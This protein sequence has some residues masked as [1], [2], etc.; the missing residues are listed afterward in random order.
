MKNSTLRIIAVTW[1]CLILAVNLATADTESNEK[2]EESGPPSADKMQ[3]MADQLAGKATARV[4]YGGAQ[5]FDSEDGVFHPDMAIVVNGDRIESIGP[6]SQLDESQTVEAEVVNA[7]GWFAIPGLVDSHV[8]VGTLPAR[9]PAEAM[10]KR[11]LYSGIT[12]VRDMAGDARALADLSR[13]ALVNEM[14]SPDIH[15]AAIFAG[16]SFFK[17]PRTV[18]SGLG[19]VPGEVPWMQAITDQTSLPLAVAKAQGTWATA[20]KVY[21][22]LPGELVQGIIAEANNQQ[23]PVWSHLQV[24]PAS[25]YDSLGATSVSHVCMIAGYIDDKTKASYGEAAANAVA[26]D[27]LSPA[28]PEIEQYIAA[29]AESGTVMDATLR[30]YYRRPPP[31]EKD[32]DDEEPEEASGPW[33]CPPELAVGITRAMY[34][35]GVP[36][37]AGTDG[38]AEADDP[39]PALHEE[40]Y[41]LTEGAGLSNADA[42]RAA[43]SVAATVLGKQD[44]LGSLEAGKYASMVFLSA[45]PLDDVSNLRSVVLTVKRGNRFPRSDYHHVPVPE[46]PFPK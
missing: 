21:A 42:I 37:V 29:L 28:H 20:I 22:N 39:F 25:P 7:S 33:V 13:A 32:D 14:P 2:G 45:N 1:I 9:G 18:T 24:F 44:D 26:L 46:L 38:S 8:H 3:S 34:L 6:E 41:Y 35:A 40:I 16:P 12:T 23:F 30:L 36:I 31:K 4:I 17:D 11:Y 27:N 19:V 10:L 43:T 5:V 15:F